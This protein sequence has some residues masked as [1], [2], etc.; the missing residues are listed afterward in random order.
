M[1]PS[2]LGNQL[3]ADLRRRPELGLSNW[4]NDLTKSMWGNMSGNLSLHLWS[5][6]W[7]RLAGTLAASLRDNDSPESCLYMDPP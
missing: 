2:K 3:S 1:N 5:P 7:D 4:P 6:L